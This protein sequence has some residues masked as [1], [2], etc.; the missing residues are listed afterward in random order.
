MVT[1]A[2]WAALQ[3]ELDRN[4]LRITA[5][6]GALLRAGVHDARAVPVLEGAL[7]RPTAT[8]YDAQTVAAVRSFQ[9]VHG[10]RADGVVGPRTWAALRG[11]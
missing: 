7:R 9:R 6:G 5:V 2:T 4:A 1:R 3:R 8:R 11:L 10:L